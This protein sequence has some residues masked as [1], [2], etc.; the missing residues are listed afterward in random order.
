MLQINAEREKGLTRRGEEDDALEI[1][2]ETEIWLYVKVV[3]AQPGT[4]PG[5]C[6]CTNF[7]WI[8]R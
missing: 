6:R 8:L 5:E 2:Q 7:S 1:V 4:R 3:Y